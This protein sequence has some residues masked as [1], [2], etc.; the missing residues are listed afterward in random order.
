MS[1]KIGKITLYIVLTL[2]L[3]LTFIPFLYMITTSL[4]SDTYSLP[5]PPVIIPKSF[6]VE[7]YIQV[8]KSNNFDRYFLNSVFVSITTMVLNVFISAMTAYGF[9]K[10]KFIGKEFIFKLFIFSMMVPGI[11]NI[12][13][14]YTVLKSFK[15]INTYTGL[16]IL[17][18]GSG[19]AGSTFFLRSFFEGIPKEL[20]ES[21]TIDGGGRWTIFT[22]I[23]LPLSAPAIGTFSIFAFSGTWDEFF[24]A[25]TILKDEAKRTLPIAIRLFEGKHASDYGLIFAASIIAVAPIILIFTI[26]QKQL[27]RGGISEGSVKG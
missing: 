7:N 16:I 13:P 4:T 5:Y 25:L 3:V 10:F 8:W 11:L 18:I 17:Y 24:A 15:L 9:A 26:F 12:I 14:Q 21:V 6:Y 1:N 20:E 27:V 2:G 23:I 19:I 22:R